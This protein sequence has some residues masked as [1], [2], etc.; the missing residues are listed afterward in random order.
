M[1][2]LFVFYNFV[3]LFGYAESLLLPGLFCTCGERGLL[4]SCG[5]WASRYGGFSHC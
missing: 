5:V 3:Y 1:G 4:S 2:L